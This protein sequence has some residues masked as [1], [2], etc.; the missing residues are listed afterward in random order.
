MRVHFL[1]LCLTGNL[2]LMAS[3]TGEQ[4]ALPAQPLNAV[5]KS[6]EPANIAEYNN[7]GGFSENG[8]LIADFDCPDSRFFP[9]IDLKYWDKTPAVNNRLPSYAETKNG[10]AIHHYGERTN[11]TI[12]PYGMTLPKLAYRRHPL[13]GKKELVVVIQIVQSPEDTIVG[14]RY[15]T[16]GCGGS[17]IHQYQFLTD[18]EVEEVVANIR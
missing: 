16:G 4:S 18:Q 13:S 15:L 11:S 7:T 1:Y 5:E 10:S 6:T 12:K 8:Q 3:C 9:P 2:I 17:A 14:F